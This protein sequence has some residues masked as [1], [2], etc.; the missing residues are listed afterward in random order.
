MVDLIDL[1]LRELDG[2]D[3]DLLVISAMIYEQKRPWWDSNPQPRGLLTCLGLGASAVH[4][5]S[6]SAQCPFWSQGQ[7]ARRTPGPLAGSGVRLFE[8][9]LEHPERRRLEAVLA[10]KGAMDL[11]FGKQALKRA[12][13]GR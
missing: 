12:P 11:A 4:R 7:E 9:L 13:K 3:L 6:S 1:R 10:P 8:H 5:V 2:A